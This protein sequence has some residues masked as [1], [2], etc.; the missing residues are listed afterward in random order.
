MVAYSVRRWPNT[1]PTLD[2]V[3]ADSCWLCNTSLAL[4]TRLDC[5]NADPPSA[6]LA[7]H[8]IYIGWTSR[9]FFVLYAQLGRYNYVWIAL[10]VWV[11]RNFSERCSDFGAIFG[12][13]LWKCLADVWYRLLEWV[14]SHHDTYNIPM[15]LVQSWASVCDVGPA[16]SQH[17]VSFSL[18]WFS[19]SVCAASSGRQ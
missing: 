13:T 8:W 19:A 2:I 1:I 7:Q 9:V 10:K 3:S 15:L 12:S 6:T 16:F 17:C 11:N 18:C 14:P 4:D 5:V